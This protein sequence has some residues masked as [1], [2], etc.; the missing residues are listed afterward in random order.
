[1]GHG[2]C[3]GD[4]LEAQAARPRDCPST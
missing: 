2:T 4:W 1:M 3:S